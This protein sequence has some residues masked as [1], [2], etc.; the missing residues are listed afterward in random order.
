MLPS[1]LKCLKA[2]RGTTLS[3]SPH[4]HVKERRMIA[5]LQIEKIE[6]RGKYAGVKI[7]LDGEQCKAILDLHHTMEEIGLSIHNQLLAALEEDPSILEDRTE[8]EIKAE[9]MIE[10]QKSIL[11][12]TAM[13]HGGDWKAVKVKS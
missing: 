1:Y 3:E 9:L 7:H 10:A 5:Y 2:G 6:R 4:S 12:L 8:E 11:K 13:Q